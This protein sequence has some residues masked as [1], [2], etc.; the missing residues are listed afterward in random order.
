MPL[1]KAKLAIEIL[2]PEL[3]SIRRLIED[4]DRQTGRVNLPFGLQSTLFAEQEAG[5]VGTK[6]QRG[7]AIY[8]DEEAVAD[9]LH[10]LQQLRAQCRAQQQVKPQSANAYL[11]LAEQLSP[12]HAAVARALRRA[13]EGMQTAGKNKRSPY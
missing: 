10:E 11:A 4:R 6:A 9:L 5:R 7:A 2:K 8:F 3:P 13:A 1:I 12:R